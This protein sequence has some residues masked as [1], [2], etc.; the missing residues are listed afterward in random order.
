MGTIERSAGPSFALTSRKGFGA[1]SKQPWRLTWRRSPHV[2]RV[3]ASEIE[4]RVVRVNEE[5]RYVY[6]PVSGKHASTRYAATAFALDLLFN[7]GTWLSDYAVDQY[8][9]PL[10]PEKQ[11]A[12]KMFWIDQWNLRRIELNAV[13]GKTVHEVV[14]RFLGADGA[15][16]EGFLDE[17]TIVAAQTKDAD[18]LEAVRTTRG[19]H[20]TD[21]FSRGNTAPLVASPHGAVFGLPMTD[22]SSGS[23]PYSYLS[24]NRR[25]DNRP[26]IQAFAT[27]HLPSPW[28]GDRGVFEVMPSPLAQPKTGRVERALGFDRLTGEIDRADRYT[29]QLDGGVTAEMTAARNAIS[30]RFH[31]S[32]PEGSII[33]D[34]LGTVSQVKIQRTV[35]RLWVSCLLNDREDAPQHYIALEAR[36]SV[37]ND[38]LSVSHDGLLRGSVEIAVAENPL[39]E[40]VIGVSTLGH[41]EAQAHRDSVSSFDALHKNSVGEWQEMLGKVTFTGAR[42]DQHTALYSDLYRLFLYPNYHSEKGV[43]GGITYRSPF[44]GEVKNGFFSANNGFWDTYRTCWPALA[45]LSPVKAAELANGFVE[46]F[47]DGGFVSRWSAPGAI[48]LMTGTSSDTVFAGL[49]AMQTPGF[50]MWDAYRSALKNATVPSFNPGLGRKGLARGI[51]YGY[52]SMDT[53]EGMSW[54]H[55][56]AINDSAI[57]RMAR[58]LASGEENEFIRARLHDEERYFAA[59]ALAY[60]EI[61]HPE[62]KF[63]MGRDFEGNWRHPD[64][65]FDPRVWGYDYTETNAWGA[66]F[67]VPHDG[68]GLAALYGGEDALAQKLDEFFTQKETGAEEF[69]GSYGF[70]IHEMTEA[71]D[72]RMGMLGLSNQPAHHIPFMYCFTGRHDDA[73]RIVTE[74]R[75]RLFIGS[76][77]GQGFPGDEDNGEMSGWHFFTAI[78][79]YPLVPGSGNFIL[80]PP[81]LPRTRIQLASG[82]VLEVRVAEEAAAGDPLDGEGGLGRYVRAVTVDGV[83]WNSISI[84][85]EHVKEGAVIEFELSSKPLGWASHARPPSFSEEFGVTTPLRDLTRSGLSATDNSGENT[86]FLA[87]G[88]SIEFPLHHTALPTLYTLT[89][90]EAA[91]ASWLLEVRDESGD[92]ITCDERRLEIFEWKRQTRPFSCVVTQACSS[93]RLVAT[94]EI[95]IRQFEIFEL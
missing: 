69:C 94:S 41:E 28:I 10:T 43:D 26:A 8:D 1:W 85:Y 48:D 37:R 90:E 62:T 75:D 44:N 61:F 84:D 76:D 17:P 72:V 74:A 13:A 18:P 24:H 73:H 52:T 71:R 45:L 82:G 66:A 80:V 42:T 36:G 77:F 92:W 11:G 20:S 22:A 89:L 49:A 95:F 2:L 63:F 27:S 14:A 39:V 30:M 38:N 40:V 91:Q 78:G 93:I 57:A 68:A 67:T 70:V 59:R 12:A 50:E 47:R 58:Q 32:G 34:H 86:T 53:P 19:S 29:V 9:T 65:T 46:H 25:S 3:R 6:F 56:N 81:M 23:W 64:K 16:A 79:L 54:T 33:F 51:F 87:P 4:G 7:D 60:Q 15:T 21:R 5:F 31:F 88:E 83:P 35:S 55:D